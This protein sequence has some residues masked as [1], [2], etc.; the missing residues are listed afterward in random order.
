MKTYTDLQNAI[1]AFMHR[2]AGEFVVGGYDVLLRAT[3]NAKDYCQRALKFHK[4]FVT[5]E[6]A[7]VGGGLNNSLININKG[8]IYGGS[9]MVALRSVDRA[10]SIDAAT[11]TAWPLDIYSYEAW[12]DELQRFREMGT[13]L[14]ER[15][16][17]VLVL[18][19]ELAFVYPYPSSE[20]RVRLH[21][22][23]W[24]PDIEKKAMVGVATSSS[25]NQVVMASATFATLGVRIGDVV[26]VGLKSALVVAVTETT[27]T[28][29]A[30]I[31]I[32]GD[33]FTVWYLPGTQTN[34]LIEN[35]FDF[36]MYRSIFELNF[37]LKEDER[38]AISDS[39]LQLTWQNVVAWNE[40]VVRNS[41][42]DAKLN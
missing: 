41:T 25:T 3:N 37:F 26:T 10:S 34:F 27:L 6:V 39:M 4:A 21:G 18:E 8:T 19:G 38:V 31:C 29:T 17:S 15:C 16:A 22:A 32:S 11:G 2:Q 36:L 33:T 35:C 12:H 42:T 40:T 20:Y 13:S 30:H 24:L 9:E 5:T 14:A 7:S 28:I 23:R 1:C